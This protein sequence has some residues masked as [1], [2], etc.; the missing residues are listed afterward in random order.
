MRFTGLQRTYRSAAGSVEALHAVDGAFAPGAIGALVGP[1][2][3]GKSTLL[4]ILGGI[5]AADAG[6]VVV[7]GID[8]RRL[9]GAALRGFRRTSV[10][11]LAQ[12]AAANLIPQLTL[13]EQLGAGGVEH[14]ERVGLAHRLDAV[15]SALSGGEQARA[16]LA[17]GLSRGTS[18]VL[19]D[20][21][22]AELDR[23]AAALVVA[24]LRA[25]ATDGRTVVVATHDA[26][27]VELADVRLE[28]TLP[29]VQVAHETHV[30]D[31][32]DEPVIVLEQLTKSYG[33]TR[34]V[35]GASLDVRGGE[36]AVLLGRSGSGKS[37]LLMAAGDWLKPDSG[38]VQTPGTRWHGTAHLAQRFGLL[39]ELSVAENVGLPLRLRSSNDDARV[40]DV[41]A[42]L[43]L[44]ELGDRLPT[45]TSIGQQQRTALARALVDRPKALLADEPT[46]HQDAR[47]AALVWS[48]LDVACAEGTACLI[49][50]H[51]EGASLHADR[52][53]RIEDG[54]VVD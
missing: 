44:S 51:D 31:L 42:R 17:V 9:R 34:V 14:A 22:T 47:S 54:R 5:D 46:S 45:E 21:P 40:A 52:V 49:A 43:G 32:S 10:T 24:E 48:A 19:L 53:W 25:A 6:E 38:T 1:S 16:A 4:R 20:E 3:S 15:A 29:T 37:T 12:R 27:L 8:V 23:H 36:I 26:E 11:F 50:T 13:R 35:D 28:L 30:R 41:L 39:P 33:G 7:D 18:V 2:G